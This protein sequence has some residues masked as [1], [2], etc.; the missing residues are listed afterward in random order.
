MAQTTPAAYEQYS[1][2]AL[3]HRCF[4]LSEHPEAHADELRAID[5]VIQNR[6]GARYGMAEGTS[7][8]VRFAAS[9]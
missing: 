9:V 7:P 5:S 3:M 8:R 2:D 4:E 6:L 1:D